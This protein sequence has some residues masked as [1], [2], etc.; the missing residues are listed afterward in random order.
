MV[1]LEELRKAAPEDMACNAAYL[2]SSLA[3]TIRLALENEMGGAGSEQKVSA[4]ANSLNLLHEL[5]TVVI[6]GTEVLERRCKAGV[7]RRTE[8]PNP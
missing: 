3:V 1:T 4:A 6:D 2:A 7:F 8:Q 5:L